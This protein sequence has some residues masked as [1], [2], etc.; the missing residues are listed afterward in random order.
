MEHTAEKGAEVCAQVV[1]ND[2]CLGHL[3]HLRLD[4]SPRCQVEQLQGRVADYARIAEHGSL[5]I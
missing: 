4:R 2:I 5:N 1:A 3:L